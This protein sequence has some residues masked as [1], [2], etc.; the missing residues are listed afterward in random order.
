MISSTPNTPGTA[1]AHQT[2]TPERPN[3]QS[4]E[5]EQFIEDVGP[6][7]VKM[8]TVQVG[9]RAVAEELAQDALVRCIERWETVKRTERPDAWAFKVA[10][11]LAKSSWRRAL[12]ARRVNSHAADHRSTSADENVDREELLMLRSA[13]RNLPDRQRAAVVCRH[14]LGLDV[15]G[16]ADVLGCAEGTVKA[17]THQGIASLRHELLQPKLLEDS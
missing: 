6:R 5:L 8:L 15:R 11:N 1:A 16:T 3:R 2:A 7:L 17:L 14:L 13:L 9:S 12:I 4:F 10:F